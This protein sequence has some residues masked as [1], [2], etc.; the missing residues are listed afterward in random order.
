MAATSLQHSSLRAGTAVAA[1][2]A[3]PSPP[4]SVVAGG[5]LAQATALSL[6][7]QLRQKELREVYA[8]YCGRR[9]ML[10][11]RVGEAR[12]RLLTVQR[13]LAVA[14][15]H[16][17]EATST[18]AEVRQLEAS[19][20]RAAE[21]VAALREALAGDEAALATRLMAHASRLKILRSDADAASAAV[22]AA[23]TELTAA[24][25]PA[26]IDAAA[27][28]TQ[29]ATAKAEQIG[30]LRA[31]A[32]EH[33]ALMGSFVRDRAQRLA[34]AASAAESTVTRLM[35]EERAL[36]EEANTLADTL[37]AKRVEA[38]GAVGRRKALLA[39]VEQL[40][41]ALATSEASDMQRLT[42]LQNEVLQ[43]EGH[44]SALRTAGVDLDAVAAAP[45][46]SPAAGAL[47]LAAGDSGVLPPAV[48]AAYEDAKEGE[49][50]KWA[51]LVEAEKSAGDR[52]VEEVRAAGRA[53]YAELVK[54]LE[55]KYVAEFETALHQLTA[56]QAADADE[57]RKLEARLDELRAA[58]DR[59]RAEKARL[60]SE[61]A[62]AH[63]EAS[64]EAASQRARLSALQQAVRDAWREKGV[65]AATVVEFLRKVQ[66]TLPYSPSLAT[67]YSSKVDELKS[68]APLL[69]LITRREVLL[70]RLHHIPVAIQEIVKSVSNPASPA[71][72]GRGAMVP[73]GGGGRA[74]ALTTA[75]LE[76]KQAQLTQLRADAAA[77]MDEVR[78]IE[79]RLRV[80]IV[81][82]EEGR[83]VPFL[84][85]GGRYL[86]T[87]APSSAAAAGAA[88]SAGGG[89]GASP[90]RT[91]AA[92]ATMSVR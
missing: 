74:P 14:Q 37:T 68:A 3:P 83:G 6:A 57:I 90:T 67:V 50:A 1:S 73:I 48:L 56:R 28:A 80:Q 13:A 63:A 59:A 35:Q 92:G 61:V 4:G 60:E 49:R 42:A 22:K 5:M 87:L 40:K 64:A 76:A 51:A 46:G 39:E 18:T 10:L 34:E 32:E 21:R 52:R 23:E 44:I 65:D 31:A 41:A 66:N 69:R 58:A 72:S 82:W 27:V 85:R 25:H 55:A 16:A 12:D 8:R 77:A 79:A 43:L 84:Y 89:A 47:V 38:E 70:Y 11:A 86:D 33:E 91:T 2:T 62:A 29:L 30:A 15:E 81:A 24:A 88:A 45:A 19:V 26:S 9:D 78:E 53:Q 71:G 36:R 17:Y 54:A 7:E 20:C 75:E